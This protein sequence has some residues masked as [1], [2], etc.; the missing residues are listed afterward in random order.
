MPTQT[1]THGQAHIPARG[2]SL[3]QLEATRIPRTRSGRVDGMVQHLDASGSESNAGEG[4]SGTDDYASLRS[5]TIRARNLVASPEPQSQVPPW[6]TPAAVEREEPSLASLLAQLDD[7]DAGV[8][9]EKDADAARTLAAV[10]CEHA[11]CGTTAG[12][13]APSVSTLFAP[14]AVATRDGGARPIADIP[15]IPG[16]QTEDAIIVAAPP[17]NADAEATRVAELEAELAR[18]RAQ[19]ADMLARHA[20]DESHMDAS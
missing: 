2:E 9:G 16:D 1:R 4:N 20:T 5:S 17:D 13:V 7:V 10:V 15:D 14:D 3:A 11:P 18:S 19:L 12:G 8:D 6:P